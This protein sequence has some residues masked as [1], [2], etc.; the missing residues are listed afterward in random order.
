V[1]ALLEIAE[2]ARQTMRDCG[3]LRQWTDG[4]PSA[5]VLE[6]DIDRGVSYVVEREGTVVATFALVP[7]PDVTYR[8]IYEGEWLNDDPYFVIHRIAAR[9][10]ARGV[11]K[12]AMDFG[13]G[14]T[15]NIRI[16]THRDNCIMRHLLG[17]LGFAYCGIIFLL[18]GDE[19]LAYQKV[20]EAPNRE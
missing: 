3:N 9:R 7:G 12:E 16:D 10:G 17:K 15:E 11:L 13:F 6:G 18:N 2:E 1:P 5:E 19:R 8:M 4:Y 14:M 20:R